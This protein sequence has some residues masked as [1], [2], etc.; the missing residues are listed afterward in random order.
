MLKQLRQLLLLLLPYVSLAQPVPS[1]QLTG[2]LGTPLFSPTDVAI[3]GQG[4]IYVLE[5]NGYFSVKPGYV[6]KLDA[7]GHFI[8]RLNI[9]KPNYTPPY[10]CEGSA[11]ALD[12][13]GNL[14]LADHGAGEVR[15]L[16]PSGQLLL[17][18]KDRYWRECSLYNPTDL[19]VDAAGNIFVLDD[20]RLQKF[21]AQGVQQWEYAL[22]VVVT[23]GVPAV[24]PWAVRADV[25]GN[26]YYLNS[27]YSITKLSATGQV[28]QTIVLS[29]RGYSSA[30]LALDAAGN[31][32]VGLSGGGGVYKFDPTGKLLVTLGSTISNGTLSLAFDAAGKLYACSGGNLGRGATLYKFD[33]TGPEMMRWGGQ[34]MG[35]FIAQNNAGEY[36]VYEFIQ[37]QIIKYAADGRELLRFGGKGSTDD[38]F[39]DNTGSG[40]VVTGLA[41]DT[42]GNVYAAGSPR[43]GSRLKKFDSQGRFLRNIYSGAFANTQLSSLAIDPA[44]NIYQADR[45]TNQVLKL[46]QQGKLLL[47]LGPGGPGR[48]QFIV[49]QAVATD[50]LGCVYVVDSSGIQVRKFAPSGQFLRRTILRQ[51][52]GIAYFAPNNPVSLSV[53][54]SG[55]LFI[56][57]SDWDSVQ[58]VDRAGRVQ[59]SIPNFLGSVQGISV[60]KDGTR[61]LA[62]SATPMVTSVFAT[63]SAPSRSSSRIQ[64]R[65]FQ[66]L[67]RDCAAQATEPN[68]A[69]L[70]VVTEPGE[71]YGVS[72]EN[73]L[74]TILADTGTY[75]VRQL[76]PQEPGRTV[77]QT[78]ATAPVVV[79][80]AN[81]NATLVGPDFGDQVSTSPY[82]QVAIAANRR[83]RCFRNLTTV[84]YSNTGY[85]AA[86]NA[87][88]TV[89]MPPEVVLLSANA[90]YTRDPSGN[91]Q[92]A[93]GTLP[94]Y[95]Q[96]TILIQ[97]SVVCGNPAIRGQTVCTKAWITPTNRYP[98]PPTGEEASVQ[99]LGKVQMGNQ[100]RF[101]L[102]N[103]TAL[104]MRDSLGLRVYQNSALALQHRYWLAAGDSLVLRVAA[105]QPVVR[106]EADQPASH[107]TQRLASSTVEVRPLSAPGQINPNMVALLPDASGPEVAEDCQPIRDSYDPNDKLVVP[108]GATAQH[109]TP[110]GVP[111]RYQVRFQNTGTDDAYRVQVVDTLAPELDVRTLRVTAASHPYHLQVSGQGRPV[112]TFTF[113]GINLPPSTRDATGSNGFVQF[114]IQPKAGLPAK[115]LLAN[116]ADIF[117]DFNPPV[118]T[119]A[120]VNRLYDQPLVVEPAVALTYADVQASPTITQV[121]P[122][123]GRAGTLITLGG[124]RFGVGPATNVV[125]FNGVV[126]PVLSASATTLTVRVPAAAT[127]G[128]IQV[129]TS[130]GAGRWTQSFTVHQP[131]TLTAITPAEGVPGSMVT[132]TGS[133]FASVPAQDTVWVGGMPAVVQQASATT[134]Q[135]VVPAGAPSGPIRVATLGGQVESAQAFVVWY[136]PVLSRFSPAQGKAGDVLTVVGSNFA[137]ASRTKVTLGPAAAQTL[138][139]TS[140]T[141]Q[142]RVPVGSESGPLQVQ[143]P[144]GLAVSASSF[145][146][147]PAPSI[148]AFAP[149][150]AS[151]GEL[152]TLTGQHFLVNGQPDTVYVGGVRAPVLTASATSLTIRVPRGALSGPL[153]VAGV[154]GRSQSATT[155]TVL[156]VT[157]A[158]AITVYPNPTHGAVTLDWLRADCAVEQVQ[159]YN[160]LGQLLTTLD[161]RQQTTPSLSIP[162]AG[163]KGLY[164]LVIHTSQGSVSKRI[165][166]Y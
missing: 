56:S 110:T 132:L 123:Q 86:V 35:L 162:F 153:T 111:L 143:T 40:E 164:V 141:L 152:V 155:F 44:T 117:F 62:L 18:F 137:L 77:Q 8:T 156:A 144:G 14:Y 104:N 96:G 165:T 100:V 37:Q 61:L 22:P 71:Y 23:P 46:D 75:S 93:V 106:L 99:V 105:T 128:S 7:Q 24:H 80:V 151:V 108:A 67:N 115:A 11:L 160:A 122:A 2:V 16:S 72:D 102:R 31:F 36:Y 112:L 98:V 135:V 50:E 125:R 49:P 142:V 101:V 76:L 34:D 5:D 58:V 95:Q 85:A 70:L 113:A 161:L 53:D 74:Y 12:A 92:F 127:S 157:A 60:T 140:T 82:L 17:T 145:T 154:G 131:P 66:D 73:G 120:T 32:Y 158:E 57:R 134:L 64:G 163:Q 10:G 30:T 68:L 89:A 94:P 130:E 9:R 6:N 54:Q 39:E 81:A 166:F 27:D 114:S 147:L 126:A 43:Y 90:P 1:F 4:F 116:E 79:R 87:V 41:V 48:G 38:K 29:Q 97:D 146:F 138:Q 91:Y 84:T 13:R 55:T 103:A 107:P 28:L 52:G 133:H 59:P 129:A 159:I 118:R 3:D 51:P 45:T 42:D 83:R 136:P 149:A 148:K 25:A 65:I 21:N 139:A 124:N 88:V 26:V 63:G 69:G 150:Q 20:L 121:T 47:R 109:Y 15:K 19:T 33:P 119:N 78:C